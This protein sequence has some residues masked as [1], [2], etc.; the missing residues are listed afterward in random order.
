MSRLARKKSAEE[1]HDHSSIVCEEL[2]AEMKVTAPSVAT[3]DKVL[4]KEG[5]RKGG[6]YTWS[7]WIVQLILDQLVNGTPPAA[8]SPN[9]SFRAA[10]AMPRVRVIVQELPS[11]NFIRSCRKIL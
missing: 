4:Q 7:I 9:I 6:S 10:L 1:D 8:I 3:I 11:I 5:A 2:K